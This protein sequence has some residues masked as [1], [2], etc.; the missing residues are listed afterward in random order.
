MLL[1]FFQVADLLYLPSD[2]YGYKYVLVVVDVFSKIC[3]AEPIKYR[4]A[5]AVLKA[6]E[7]LYSRKILKIPEILQCNGGSEFKGIEEQRFLKMNKRGLNMLYQ[8]GIGNIH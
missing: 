8:I 2:A 4:D 3:D 5:S 6:F 7:K 1:I